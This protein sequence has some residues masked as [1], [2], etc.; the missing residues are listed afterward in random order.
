MRAA[1]ELLL[2]T[3]AFVVAVALTWPEAPPS[4]RAPERV[5]P[6]AHA[7]PPAERKQ[8]ASYVLRA[9]L[10]PISHRITAEG[11]IEFVNGSTTPLR[12]LFFHL[13]LNAFKNDRTLYLRSPFGAGRSGRRARDYGYVDVKR[14]SARE[15][16]GVDLW[17]GRARH[18]PGDPEDETDIEVP[19]PEPLEPGARLTLDVSFESQLPSIIERTGHFGS[20]H[21]AGQW[22]PKIARLEPDGRFAHFAFHPQAEFYSDFGRYDVTLD[23]PERFVVGA[24]GVRV[25][26]RRAG[27]RRLERYVAEPVHDFAWTAWDGFAEHETSIDGVRV[28]MLLPAGHDANRARTENALRFALPH[29]SARYGRYPYPTLTVVHPPEG[30]E[31]AGGMEYPTLITTGGAWYSAFTGTRAMEA[32]TVHELAHQWFYGLVASNEV[33]SPFLDE[34][35]TSFAELAALDAWLGPASFANLLGLELS[36]WSLYRAFSGDRVEDEPVGKPA[37]EF[38]SFQNLGALVYARTAVVLETL[39]RVFGRERLNRALL[40]YA[41]TFR[42][43]HPRPRDLVTKLVEHLGE[44]ARAP[45]ERALFDRGRV[46]YVVREIQTARA[47]APAGYFERPSGRERVVAA[48][49][50]ENSYHSRTTVYRHGTLELPVEVLF[51]AADGST[52][53]ER[54]DGRGSHRVFEGTGPSPWV[55]VV[56]DP[57]HKILLED[58]LFDNTASTESSSMPR[59]HERLAYFG[60]LLLG[61]VAP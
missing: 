43:A 18:S 46:N 39:A 47:R 45:I 14:L 5:A 7:E 28:R 29:L 13:Y 23:V 38:T 53:L 54:W 42:F 33:E 11:T 57:A 19:L 52:R 61:G 16:G 25:E 21:F 41:T 31:P 32:V 59:V 8:S 40:D 30:A 15:L 37:P 48:S 4:P 9:R 26:S 20:F 27:N 2:G 56:V 6:A 44:P 35:L 34:G 22:F 1:A 17:P 49:E 3:G 24:T 55:R 10:D 36:G 12:S 58:R 51:V 50:H 60:A